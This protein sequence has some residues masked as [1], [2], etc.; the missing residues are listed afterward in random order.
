MFG[1]IIP[2]IM[3][4][5]YDRNHQPAKYLEDATREPKVIGFVPFLRGLSYQ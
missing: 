5:K 1:R 3:E 4:K 2:H